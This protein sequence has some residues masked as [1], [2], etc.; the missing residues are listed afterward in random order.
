MQVHQPNLQHLNILTLAH[1]EQL[2]LFGSG[3]QPLR[4]NLNLPEVIVRSKFS[5]APYYPYFGII[6]AR[7]VLVW[8]LNVCQFLFFGTKAS[9][10]GNPPP[11]H[12]ERS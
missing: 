5:C 10:T 6:F 9:S 3:V 1:T 12:Y 8:Q 4:A 2:V 11:R 7:R